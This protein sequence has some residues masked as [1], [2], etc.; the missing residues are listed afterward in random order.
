MFAEDVDFTG[1]ST[2]IPVQVRGHRLTSLVLEIARAL[3]RGDQ[4]AARRKQRLLSEMFERAEADQ[5]EARGEIYASTVRAKALGTVLLDLATSGWEIRVDEGSVYA[6]A[7]AWSAGSSGLTPEQVR[8][9]KDRARLAMQARVQEEIESES[10]RRFIFEMENVTRV[11]GGTRS[12]RTLIA[13]GPRLAA[14]LRASGAEAVQPYLQVADGNAGRDPISGLRLSDVFRYMKLF[15]SFPMKSPP[16]RTTAFLVRDAGQPLHPVCGL[17]AIASPVPRLTPRDAA[18]GWTPA[19]LEAVVLSLSF[20]DDD[21]GAHVASV[22]AQ[23]GS[24]DRGGLDASSIVEDLCASLGIPPSRSPDDLLSALSALRRDVRRHRAD[25][26]LVAILRDLRGEVLEALDAI[27]FDGLGVTLAEALERP[28]EAARHL[29]A[30]KEGAYRRW[31]ESRRVGAG[32]HHNKRVDGGALDEDAVVRDSSQDPLYVKK[33]VTQA[34]VLLR[35]WEGISPLDGEASV[36]RLS[37]LVLGGASRPSLRLTGGESVARGLRVALLQRQNRLVAAQVADVCVCGAVPPYG[38]L[39]GGKLAALLAMSREVA[40]AY[41]ARYDGRASEISS[42]MAARLVRRPANLLALTTTSFYGVGA[43]QYER[44]NLPAGD[45]AV[46]WRFVGY[47]RGH[48]TLHFSAET[49]RAMDRLLQLE[50]GRRLITSRFGE[51]P[52]E[53][54]RKIRDGLTRL[55]VNPDVLLQHGMWRLVYVAELAPAACRPGGRA[56]AREWREAGPSVEDVA[57]HWR[58]RWLSRRLS[59]ASAVIDEVERFSNEAILIGNRVRRA[60]QGRETP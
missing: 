42:Q 27:S 39:L 40:A 52:S 12:I 19:W 21:P 47:S 31:H 41:H 8:A 22:L 5:S 30:M 32:R 53:R 28:G 35:A 9:E 20:P 26:A 10:T 57:R 16:G 60:P 7:P 18:L 38:P 54:M 1:R 17:I 55:G 36:D 4:I 48:G 49:S 25:E 2:H 59:S 34:A 33:R 51:G 13:E 37:T 15:W 23:L 43:S 56:E 46:R 24:S 58:S 3:H 11:E 45:G 50:T 29:E 44:L 14:A 6:S